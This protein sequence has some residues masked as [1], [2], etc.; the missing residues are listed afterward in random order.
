ML[1][2]TA[3]RVFDEM[4]PGLCLTPPA[5]RDAALPP[6]FGPR[7]SA[8]GASLV[9][10]GAQTCALRPRGCADLYCT[11]GFDLNVPA[12]WRHGLVPQCTGPAL[13]D[14]PLCISAQGHTSYIIPRVGWAGSGPYHWDQPIRGTPPRDG[15]IQ[16]RQ[17]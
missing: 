11:R 7:A 17:R 8:N 12:A 16:M 1:T 4:G 5:A 6:P 14:V 15:A 2:C 10:E 13:V 9:L 3:H